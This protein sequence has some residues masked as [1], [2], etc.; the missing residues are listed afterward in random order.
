[1][2]FL[3]RHA[4][5]ASGKCGGM[6][7]VNSTNVTKETHDHH[8]SHQSVTMNHTGFCLT[9]PLPHH[10]YHH[11]LN[12]N[13]SVMMKRREKRMKQINANYLSNSPIRFSF[14]SLSPEKHLVSSSNPMRILKQYCKLHFIITSTEILCLHLRTLMM[15]RKRVGNWK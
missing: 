13:F 1:M 2:T 15:T 6:E 3:L 12:L 14:P 10:I 7:S 11:V 8:R 5:S 4:I 9:N